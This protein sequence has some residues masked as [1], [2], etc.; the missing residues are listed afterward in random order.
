MDTPATPV[1][2][3]TPAP[4]AP[5]PVPAGSI[6]LTPD[7]QVVLPGEQPGQAAPAAQA[8]YT[9]EEVASLGIEKLDPNR[10][11]PELLPF[12][13]SM[14][15][16]YVRKTQQLAEMRRM[17][18]T[19]A[20]PQ[21]P[22][23]QAQPGDIADRVCEATVQRA[24]DLMGIG[25][26][27][28]DEYDGKHITFLTMAG[29][30]LMAEA[31][32]QK[33]MQTQAATRQQDYNGLLAKYQQTEPNY[34]A[35]SAYVDEWLAERPFKEYQGIMETLRSGSMADIETKVIQEVRKA[36]YARN[37][38]PQTQTPGGTPPFV[39]AGRPG[40]V[41]PSGAAIPVSFGKMSA[42]EQA[43]ILVKAGLV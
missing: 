39:E 23:P 26:D 40:A 24:C 27:A 31:T 16:D 8:P 42:E 13:K 30:Q 19:P 12:Y 18:E 17:M 14:Q 34:E 29:Q 5:A 22:Q 15:A 33:E 20:A 4:A 25:R 1:A 37:G 36:W 3:P 21:A 38:A 6:G 43:Q 41:P 11:P 9:P 7:G 35:I 10:I 2:A 32:R 28:F